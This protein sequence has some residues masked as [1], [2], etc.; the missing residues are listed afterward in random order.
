MAGKN[1]TQTNVTRD[2]IEQRLGAVQ[3]NLKGKVASRKSTIATVAGI[4]AVVL[5]VLVY[6]IG[7]RSGKR[8]TTF[9][10]LRRL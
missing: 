2:D 10:E 8:K 4:G 3:N 1:N 6:L 5:V 7:R 9:V